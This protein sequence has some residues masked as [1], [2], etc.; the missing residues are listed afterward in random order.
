MSRRCV[1]APHRL[2]PDALSKPTPATSIMRLST[3]DYDAHAR[4]V[5]ARREAFELIASTSRSPVRARNSKPK[6][7]AEYIETELKASA[8]KC[9]V[10]TIHGRDVESQIVASWAFTVME[11][12]AIRANVGMDIAN[13]AVPT[14]DDTIF[15]FYSPIHSQNN[16]HVASITPP[17][18]GRTLSVW[19]LEDP[20]S[21]EDWLEIAT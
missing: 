7:T 1:E 16:E 19:E 13:G 11:Q 5:G 17:S 12:S 8:E 4:L 2:S 6:L 20:I 15:S 10:P 9:N 3:L 14:F 21:A 18:H